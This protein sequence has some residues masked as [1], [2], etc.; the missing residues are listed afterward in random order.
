[1]LPHKS[2]NAGRAAP[3]A[4]AAIDPITIRMISALVANRNRWIKETFLTSYYFFESV[5]VRSSKFIV[6]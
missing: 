1:M 4:K 2:A 5:E 3:I 6:L